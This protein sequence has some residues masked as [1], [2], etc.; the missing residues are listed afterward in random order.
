MALIV[1]KYGGTSVSDA[2]RIQSVA[3]RI[4]R[5]AKAGDRL[6]IVV[7]AMGD[8]TDEL[9]ALADQMTDEPEE[10]E[11]D[12]L[13]STGEIVSSTLL[14]MAL[15]HIGHP[16]IALSGAQAGIGTDKRYGRAR[17]LKVDPHRVEAALKGGNVVIVAGFQGTTEELDVTTL[18]RGG[19]DTTAVALTAALKAERCEIYTD[20]DG[21]YTAAVWI[22]TYTKNLQRQ[23]DQELDTLYPD[24]ARKSANVVIRKGRENYF[25]LLNME[26][27]V[28]A[29]GTGSEARIALGLLARWALASRNGDMVGGDF[30]AWLVGLLGPHRTLALT[31]RRGEC[32]Y[33]ACKHYR[34]CFIEKSVRQARRADIVIANHAL[35]LIQAALGGDEAVLPTRYVFDEGHHVFDAADS[36]FSAH[37]SGLEAAE[38]RRWLLGGEGGRRQGRA[39][40]LENRIGD[41]ITGEA[42]AESALKALLRAA[43]CLPG[44]G[45]LERLTSALPSGPVEVFLARVRTHVYARAKDQAS[46][47]SLEASTVEPAE[48]LLAAARA[49]AVALGGLQT[50]LRD[51][52]RLL[53]GRLD[54][55]AEE[56]DTASRIR[57]EAACR[58]LKRRAELTLRAWRDMLA[59]LAGEADPAFVDWFGVERS[60]RRD[61]D[62]GM[63]RH[64]VD[65]TVPFAEAVLKRAHGVLVTSATLRDNPPDTPEDWAAAEVRTGAL[66][67]AEPATRASLPSPFDYAA[68]TCV[69]VVT[70]VRRQDSAQVAAAYRELFK[71]AGG[72][73]GLF[74]AIHLLR[75]I[76]RQ[77]AGPLEEAGIT[78]LAQHVD[79]MDTGTLVDI[80][81]FEENACLLGTDAVRDGIDVP[82]RSLRL[83]VF[84]RVPWP[85]P[86][87]LHRARR[88]A[89]GGRAYDDM[90]TRLRLKQAYGRLVRKAGDRGIFVVLDAMLPTR[91]TTAF[92]DGVQVLRLGLA[93]AVAETGRFLNH[94]IDID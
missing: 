92:P 55:D 5:Q 77:I 59:K 56:L 94:N 71:A 50:P 14:A 15:K 6:V 64:W 75:Q 43:R 18:G 30:P 85:R 21:I 19:S 16:A 8:T 49:L 61:V 12:L 69:I 20:V 26:D 41:L 52:I 53:A 10:R 23:V 83:I 86:D 62:V 29:L 28:R 17:I 35:V 25:C 70:D 7:S 84:D 81:R 24:P 76:H 1:Q 33:S 58:G 39:R 91:L 31:D 57:I 89:F 72:G 74:T 4:A 40:G 88:A 63:H 44:E 73:L 54:E 45:W 78:L 80:F 27:A 3:G 34:K 32:V 93:E 90:M 38:L 37:L 48:P 9:L 2:E 46:A 79:P 13:L 82:G 68:L 60:N 47:F 11:L 51:F 36:A 87:I 65:P 22:S 67:L 66:H 42:E